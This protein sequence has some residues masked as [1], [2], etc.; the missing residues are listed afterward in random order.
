M[1]CSILILLFALNIPLVFG[2]KFGVQTYSNFSNEAMDIEIDILG[3]SYVTGYVTGATEFNNS[4]SV[5]SAP[6]NGDIYVAK[7]SPNGNLIWMKQFGGNLMDRAYDLAIGPDQNVVITGTFFG[8]LQFGSINIQS[9]QGSKDIFL[10]KLNPQGNV[11]WARKEGGGLSEN[12]YGVTIDNQ[13]NV[14]LTGQF[15]G[16]TSIAN[17]NFTSSIDPF[18]NLPSFDLFISK[19]DVNGTPQW[20][21]VGNAKKEDRG[22]AVAVD[23]QN[24]IFLC[25][26]YSDTLQ[27][28]GTTINNN[29]LNV[30]FV[31]K[32]SPSG[33]VQFFNNLRAGSCVPYDIK[34]NSS[35]QVVLAGDFLG[36]MV[37]SHDSGTTAIT[38]PFSK[39]VFVLQIN[40][41]G[42]TDWSYTL[43]SN[44]ELSARALAV[45][46]NKDVY[47]VGYFKCALTQLHQTHTALWNTIGYRDTYLLKIS[48]SGVFKYA[49]QMGGHFN[50]NAH[51]ICIS[52]VENPIICGSFI[53]DYCVMGGPEP[54]VVNDL[55]EYEYSFG[56]FYSDLLNS[57]GFHSPPVL[58][59]FVVKSVNNDTYDLNFFKGG[60]LDTT[61]SFLF[62]EYDYNI[63]YPIVSDTI[64]AC[65]GAQITNYSATYEYSGPRITYS[66]INCIS[67]TSAVGV[68]E[69]GYYGL[70]VARFDGCAS[71]TDSI[72][73]I[74]EPYP[75]LPLMSDNLNLAV[76]EPG[77]FYWHYR[78]C[79]PD[80][81][82]ISFSN[83]C[84]GCSIEIGNSV[85]Y[86]QDTLPHYYYD[87]GND[88]IY[89]V[90]ITRG[91]CQ[92]NGYFLVGFDHHE[93][94]DSINL[95]IV[96]LNPPLYS[97]TITIC[98]GDGVF[99]YGVD[100]NECSIGN[101]PFIDRPWL[102]YEWLVNGNT[103]SNQDTIG[104]NFSPS[105]T[106]WYTFELNL[107]IGKNDLCDSIVQFY[108]A[109]DSFYII[110][111]P[112][113]PPFATSISGNFNPVLCAGTSG[114]L[115]ASPTHPSYFWSGPGIV[116]T[117]ADGGTITFNEPGIYSYSGTI[118]D[119]IT[120]CSSNSGDY[121]SI[122][123]PTA[124]NLN[125]Y[126]N[127]SIICPNSSTQFSL[128][129]DYQSYTWYGPN[130]NVISN[131]N[132]CT[133]SIA[134]FYYCTL[135]DSN[136]CNITT[137]P[138]ELTQYQTPSIIV[139][140]QNVI[141]GN[142]SVTITV[143]YSGSPSILWSPTG[144]TLDHLI[145]NQPGTYTVTVNQCGIT[146]TFQ[147]VIIDG[148]FSTQISSD[149]NQLCYGDEILITGS[150][151][152]VEYQWSNGQFSGQFFTVT[153]PGV[154]NA[155][156]T[157]QF[158]CE[159]NTNSII[160][161]GVP[162]S[163]PP[164]IPSQ[165]ICENGNVTFTDFSSFTLNW[166]DLDSNFLT[167][168][169]SLTLLN[170]NADTSF[171]VAYFNTICPLVY[172]TVSVDFVTEISNFSIIGNTHLCE[173]EETFLQLICD[174]SISF[175]W[176]NGDSTNLISP[177]STTGTY[178]ITL[179]QCEFE[180]TQTIN[181][182]D[183]SFSST[184][185]ASDTLFCLDN[186]VSG[187]TNSVNLTASPLN[188]QIVWSTGETNMNTIKISSPGS[189][190]ATLTNEFGCSSQ[191]TPIEI[192]AVDCDGEIPNII[193]ANS[194]GINDYF[195]IESAPLL[196]NNR[197]MIINRWGNVVLDESGYRNT[198]NGLDVVDGVYFYVFYSD[199][200]N[201]PSHFKQGFFH[202]M[203]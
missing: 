199:F 116:T 6:G 56:G 201:N 172:S 98:E 180:T 9:N 23:S 96:L 110:L 111:V 14:I 63:Q 97:D 147:E 57:Y 39:R 42:Q 99:V 140:P 138:F 115:T 117:S 144:S 92:S 148:S 54:F 70:T 31:T 145:V 26:Q 124:P 60:V 78:F 149:E 48:N 84:S 173:N 80:S 83:L 120:G 46:S 55:P 51:G 165:S 190:Y 194:D 58:N 91:D 188:A 16:N 105:Q 187:T 137:S 158:G 126:V 134:G 123:T 182:F 136:F 153:E 193:T 18:T 35:D 157:N 13:N 38:N 36:N 191:T 61:E 152:N 24:N 168:T 178:S 25:G 113:P 101:Y 104:T 184:L 85:V 90:H 118:L 121:V 142:E 195:I 197:L 202:V 160:I 141:C 198:F 114:T 171:L 68:S 81:V 34:V 53:Y 17:Q 161:N 183:A 132:T 167:S 12:S 69:T 40:N 86:Y 166:Y 162:E 5:L 106:G 7:Y 4:V 62:G 139:N 52:S 169:N 47:V 200:K 151:P 203:K 196:P 131:S 8:S 49:K 44:N 100:L 107:N 159:V 122:G 50:D 177:I 73:V 95:G 186:V 108:H 156:V 133:A 130:G 119:T 89:A 155:T 22:M 87:T 41:N 163:S 11:I 71:S 72:Y 76:N 64:T 129:P 19:Y 174:P 135:V 109:I 66:W 74:I 82:Q 102:N 94:I 37:Y 67:D 143:I 125:D 150:T 59:S 164:L 15:E 179:Y 27:F 176:Y 65:I 170:V 88:T 3:N 28:A 30:G 20:V 154:Y 93:V 43:G 33:Q 77:S 192:Y 10:L 29:G 32:L 21:K 45:D 189:Y 185:I 2:Q 146:T 181:V 103:N 127:S 75:P 175:L 128:P 112:F 79:S 1:K